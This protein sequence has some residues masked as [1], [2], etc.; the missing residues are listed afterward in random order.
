MQQRHQAQCECGRLVPILATL[1]PW[2]FMQL[3]AVCGAWKTISW[4]HALTPPDYE[5]PKPQ[6]LA[7]WNDMN[8]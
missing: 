6:Q 8:N 2:E 4:N 3:C 7:L 1:S 5:P